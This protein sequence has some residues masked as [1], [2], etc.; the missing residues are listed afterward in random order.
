MSNGEEASPITTDQAFNR[1][2]RQ[3]LPWLYSLARRLAENRAEDVVQECLVRA[4]KSFDRLRDM[5]AAPAWFRQI[6]INCAKDLYRKDMRRPDETSLEDANQQT[7]YRSIADADPLPYSETV[8]VDFLHSFSE[9]DVWNVL[10]RLEPKYR[11]PLV[12]VHMEGVTT[13]EVSRMLGVPLNTLLS[14]LH[15]G[16]KQF[17]TQMWNYAE[18]KQLLKNKQGARK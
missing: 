2:A 13:K 14:W 17:E 4:Y 11:V 16:R 8:H 10:D 9:E 6:L 1:V 12:L 5:E 15:R 7:L 18:E 3:Q